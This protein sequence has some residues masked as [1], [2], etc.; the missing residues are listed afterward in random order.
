MFFICFLAWHGTCSLLRET[1]GLSGPTATKVASLRHL[2]RRTRPG[3]ELRLCR[4][5]L[6]D[7]S[8]SEQQQVHVRNTDTDYNQL[9]DT[10]RTDT[11]VNYNPTTYGRGEASPSRALTPVSIR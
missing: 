4:A 2:P 6:S 10:A 3:R 1:H 9:L 7:D 5:C 8:R 11:L